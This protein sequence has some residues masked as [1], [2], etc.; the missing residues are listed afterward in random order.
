[1]KESL[2]LTWRRIPERYNLKATYCENCKTY[3]FPPRAICPKCRRKEKTKT[4]YLKGTG[5]VYSY[6]KIYVPAE[7]MEAQV[8]YYLAVIEL[9]EGVKLTSQVVD[10]DELSIGDRVEV[11]FRKI[12]QEDPE[13]L[14]HYGFKFRKIQ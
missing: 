9:D 1:M 4:V 2:P 10:A 11:V 6:T 14:I 7:G 5:K 8:P 12:Q 3:Y 13:G